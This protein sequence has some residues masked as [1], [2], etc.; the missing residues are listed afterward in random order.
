MKENI[1]ALARGHLSEEQHDWAFPQSVLPAE[2]FASRKIRE[3]LDVEWV[4]NDGDAIACNAGFYELTAFCFAR[5]KHTVCAIDDAPA[6]CG[7]EQTLEQ[8]SP[9]DQWCCSVG[10]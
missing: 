5:G 4:R 10:R 2:R 1:D 3:L 7:I 9:L 8:N 6:A